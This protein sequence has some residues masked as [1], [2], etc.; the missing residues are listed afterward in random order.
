[1]EV[2]VRN[3]IFSTF[4]ISSVFASVFGQRDNPEKLYKTEYPVI[5]F[6]HHL[7][8]GGNFTA[9]DVFEYEL[10]AMT[11]AGIVATSNLNAGYGDVFEEWVKVKR[12]YPE[13][14]ILFVNIDYGLDGSS[15]DRELIG[16]R[17][18][19][20]DY[21]ESIVNYLEYQRKKGAQAVK[22]YKALG[23]YLKDTKGNYIHVND[24]RF[25]PYWRK[26]GELGMPVL[27]H[28]ADP[29]GFFKKMGYNNFRYPTIKPE[30]DF[31]KEWGMSG[32]NML[33][34]EL[35]NV[36]R[37]HPNTNFV[38][39]HFSNLSHELDRLA[40]IFDRYPNFYVDNSARC[41]IVG[42]YNTQAIYDFFVKYQ[43]R[44]LFGTDSNLS[45]D[46]NST[47]ESMQQRTN[48]LTAFFKRHWS[49]FETD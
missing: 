12:K 8:F 11:A 43:D 18:D 6:H 46:K 1:M 24:K 15:A 44:I 48:Y 37:E 16:R 41:H 49:I 4:L 3:L 28:T 30:W 26:A 47:K 7:M 39:A 20:P 13:N 33:I 42:R 29:I 38:S 25:Y 36:V 21:A 19:E 34:S 27:I 32:F 14:I 2:K 10:K 9:T 40:E 5:N 23:L 31:S 17:L 22:V 35:L 45:A